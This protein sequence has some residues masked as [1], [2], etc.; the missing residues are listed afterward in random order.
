MD[1]D[2]LAE[3]LAA[4]KSGQISLN[5]RKRCFLAID[6][7]V[8]RPK[9]DPAI[10]AKWDEAESKGNAGKFEYLQLWA[11]DTSGSLMVVEQVHDDEQYDAKENQDL[12]MTK[13]EFYS[14]H[15]AWHHPTMMAWCEKYLAKAK[16]RNH[17]EKQ[18]KADPEMMQYKIQDKAQEVTG[19]RN[20]RSTKLRIQGEVADDAK[21][22]TVNRLSYKRK[23]SQSDAEAGPKVPSK[24][25]KSLK[26]M[27]INEQRNWAVQVVLMKAKS[28]LNLM[29]TKAMP[30]CEGLLEAL[31]T[32]SER[33]LEVSQQIHKCIVQGDDG[34]SDELWWNNV[35]VITGLKEHIHVGESRLCAD[36]GTVYKPWTTA[37]DACMVSTA[38]QAAS[39]SPGAGQVGPSSRPDNA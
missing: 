21:E 27:T 8:N 24:A 12:W 3:I 31:E 19:N 6:R 29:K 36:N 5:L 4:T 32:S 22:A 39:D 35:W 7:L 23:I 13:Y 20:R 38:G 11:K 15:N 9:I 14:K 1:A 17:N 16:T 28:T 33:L 37:Y 25:G 18:H 30:F 34:G 26:S 10:V 2:E